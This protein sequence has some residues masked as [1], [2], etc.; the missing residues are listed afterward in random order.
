MNEAQRQK[1]NTCH[2]CTGSG[3]YEDLDGIN[4]PCSSCDG[5]GYVLCDHGGKAESLFVVTDD[6]K[7]I[8]SECGEGRQRTDARQVLIITDK[9]FDGCTHIWIAE[10][11]GLENVYC[12]TMGPSIYAQF[13]TK[14][15]E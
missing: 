12:S 11:D 2:E 9:G 13:N 8:C 6:G 10:T 15:G 5:R 1:L 14:K 4:Q 3:V 7:R